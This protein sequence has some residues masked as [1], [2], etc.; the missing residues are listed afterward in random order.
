MS[1]TMF[2]SLP[3]EHK[4]ERQN[5]LSKCPEKKQRWR[6][7]A[8]KRAQGGRAACGLMG[9]D[10]GAGRLGRPQPWAFLSLQ[11]ARTPLPRN[12][13]PQGVETNGWR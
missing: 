1:R 11:L 10:G 6:C 13:N 2:I 4:A 9:A 12:Q 5:V 7:S 3:W 8:N